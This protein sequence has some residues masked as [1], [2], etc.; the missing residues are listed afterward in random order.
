MP[1]DNDIEIRQARADKPPRIVLLASHRTVWEYP[2][3]LKYLLIGLADEAIP[4]TLVCPPGCDVGPIVPPA[5]EVI[6]HPYIDIPVLRPYNRR[7]LLAKIKKFDPDI[8][9]CLGEASSGLA[10]W[11]TRQLGIPYILN[12]NSLSLRWPHITLSVNRCAR[13]IVPAKTIAEDFAEN[14][15]KFADRIQQINIGTFV[16]PSPACFAD[17]KHLPGILAVHPLHNTADFDPF[18]DALRRLAI[19]GYKFVVGL[20]GAGRDEKRIR[21]KL[22]KMGLL[23]IVT[24]VPYLQG[25]FFSPAGDIFVAPRPL[26]C[27]NALMLAAMCRGSV[28]AAPKGGVDDLIIENKT[29]FVFDPDD[30][31]SIYNC[32]KRILD[33]R[34]EARQIAA[35]AQQHLRQNYHVS[36]MVASTL[37]LYRRL[38]SA[39]EQQPEEQSLQ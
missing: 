17:P 35:A 7:V 26:R 5:V 23:N 28:V 34:E 14:Q 19:E 29:A 31:L 11:L 39:P 20:V 15:K 38:T 2:L 16:D 33:T 25:L 24:I 37:S 8:V 12:I 27:F 9:H 30:Q 18:L 10:R 32:L 4:V 36:D 13:I 21:K 6:V 22:G 1:D 3:Y